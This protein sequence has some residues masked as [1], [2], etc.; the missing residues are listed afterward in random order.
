MK[1]SPQFNLDPLP[2]DFELENEMFKKENKTV[3]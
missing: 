3:T 1:A 2:R